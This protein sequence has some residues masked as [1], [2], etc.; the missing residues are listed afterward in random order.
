MES[1]FETYKLEHKGLS[2]QVEFCYDESM[3]EPWKEHDG[4]GVVSNWTTRDKSPG[5]RVLNSDRGNKRYYDFAESVKIALKDGWDCSKRRELADVDPS[6]KW[7]KKEI[8]AMAVEDD[9]E[10]LRAWCNDE[11]HWAGVVVTLLDADGELTKERESLWGT[12]SSENGKYL[13]E[14][15]EELAE[16]IADRVPADGVLKVMVRI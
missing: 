6:R 16:E 3:G 12:E 15:A 2:F 7:T 10:H 5:E 1:T 11:W 9:F 13:R 8:A 14:V 4:H